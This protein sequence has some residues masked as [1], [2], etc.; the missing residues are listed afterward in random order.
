[1]CKSSISRHQT[2][3]IDTNEH[4]YKT[5]V[6]LLAYLPERTTPQHIIERQTTDPINTIT[7]TTTTTEQIT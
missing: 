3:T 7:T 4:K 1:M 6:L 2:F 5:S